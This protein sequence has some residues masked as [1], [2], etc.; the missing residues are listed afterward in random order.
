MT[1]WIVDYENEFIEGPF[2]NNEQI[3]D[4][5]LLKL[6]GLEFYNTLKE[7]KLSVLERNK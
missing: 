1:T 4:F 3:I 7:A 6:D 5:L 2:K